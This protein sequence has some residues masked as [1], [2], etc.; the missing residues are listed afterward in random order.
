M[1]D[2]VLS[3]S[4]RRSLMASGLAACAAAVSGTAHASHHFELAAARSNPKIGLT[5][6]YVFNAPEGD[7]TVFIL[8]ANFLPQPGGDL[9]DRSGLYNIHCAVDDSFKAGVTWTFGYDGRHVRFGQLDEANGA[10][11]KKGKE[12]AKLTLGKEAKLPNG[13]RV[14][15]GKAKDPFF[16]NSPGIGAFRAQSKE[17]KY[18]PD[19]WVKASGKN[20]FAGR[21]CCI[22]VLE[23]PNALLSKKIN[24]FSTVALNSH[25]SWH[26]VQYMANVLIAHS[27]L[28]EDEVLKAGYDASRPDTQ[29]D[30]GNIFSARIARSAHLAG[31]RPD[32]FAYGDEMAKRLL[33]DVMPYEVGTPAAYLVDKVN[34]RK[35]SDDAMTTT[36]TWLIGKPTNQGVKDPVNYTSAFPYIMPV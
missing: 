6:M 22:F 24:V 30:F 33:P 4:R 9:L 28:F 23:V 26:Q 20:I 31:S 10:V 8:N 21:E 32:P 2:Q 25:G 7:R 18:D 29:K 3:S 11:G 14:W 13:I 16:G 1:H 17:G 19:V 5:D 15:V 12:L 27:M 34:G 36:I 35:L